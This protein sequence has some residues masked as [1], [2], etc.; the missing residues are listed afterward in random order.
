MASPTDSGSIRLGGLTSGFDTEA[1]IQQLLAIEQRSIDTLT[2]KQDINSAKI[3]TWEDIAEQLKSF[4]SPVIT[5][6]ADG[7]TGNTLYDDKTVTTN[8][9][10]VAT[11]SASASAVAATYDVSVTTLAR[12]NVAYGSQKASNYTLPGGG[13][14]ILGG[15]TI[16]LTAGMTLSQIAA[17]ITGGSYV[18]GNE[19]TATVIDDRLVIQTANMGASAT[20]H[21]TAAGSPPFVNATDDASNILEGELGIIDGAGDLV[22][23]A[24]TSA[25]ASLTINGIAV[26]HDSN[27]LDDVISGVTLNLH[28][29]GSS[30]TLEIDVD[31]ATIKET[32]TD[33]IDSYNELR[34]M[35]LRVKEAKLNEED[36]FGLFHTDALLR[37]LFNEVRSLST[38]G[39]EMGAADWEGTVQVN[40]AA[41]IGA[42]SITVNGF[43]NAT[44][45]ITEG[46]EFVIEGDST[47]YKV[48]NSTSIAGNAATIDINPP[49]V[50][51]LASGEAV[52]LNVRT[53]ED[54]G[55][56]VRTDTVSGVEGILGVLDEGELDSMLASDVSIIKRIF[57]RSDSEEGRTG[58]ARRLYDWI[59]SHT[60]ISYLTS[61]TRSID[62]TKIDGLEELN[63]SLDE[64]I[65]RLESRMA[66][67]EQALIRQFAEMENA[68]AQAQSSGGAIASLGA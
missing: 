61:K 20:I 8:D 57:Q 64:Q 3:D 52:N 60:K 25:D 49:L 32:I 4:S 17:E 48:Q 65:D 54:F 23:E 33:F 18:A 29:Q 2:E 28:K 35:L 63:E 21:G 1:I 31:T 39:V 12:A 44:G 38:T 36:D 53:L 40:A 37:E 6:R 10:T 16:T 5:L 46:E 50:V 45:S 26:T 42:T 15:A 24:Q 66:K 14:I 19:H 30:A 56:G 62:D 58:V 34:D 9:S 43:T 22:N 41:S 27:T 13:N 55:V 47:V 67:K 59:D 51:A 68:M 11:A 7:T